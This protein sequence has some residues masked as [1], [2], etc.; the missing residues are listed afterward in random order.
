MTYSDCWIS[1]VD[2]A[3]FRP[4]LTS[5]RDAESGMRL[6]MLPPA[7]ANDLWINIVRRRG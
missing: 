2:D 3:E 6:E 4:L 7:L 5:Q 1:T